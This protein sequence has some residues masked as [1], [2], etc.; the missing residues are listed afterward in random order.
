MEI[1]NKKVWVVMDK[2]R[3]VIAKGNVRDRH[4]VRLDNENC[5]KRYLTYSTKNKAETSFSGKFGYNGSDLVDGMSSS[6]WEDRSKFLE[7]V[8]CEMVINVL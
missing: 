8:E 4:L 5:K 2:K 7:A 6:I 3:T 1:E